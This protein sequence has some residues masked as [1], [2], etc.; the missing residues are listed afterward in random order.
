[1][2]RTRRKAKITARA[3]RNIGNSR[4]IN[5]NTHRLI[6]TSIKTIRSLKQTA[7]GTMT[8]QIDF[9]QDTYSIRT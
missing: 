8:T 7:D 3:R 2:A 9:S 1:V 4:R 5:V 6:T